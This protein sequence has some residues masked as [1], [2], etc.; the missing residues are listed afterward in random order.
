MKKTTASKIKKHY[1]V[2]TMGCQM[3]EYD[4]DHLS[5]QLISNGYCGADSPDKADIIF[6]NT[7]S[8]REKA[9]QKAFSMLGRMIK[10]KKKYP[11]ILLG[12]TGCIAQQEGS[13]LLKKYPELDIV[14]GT[15]GTSD[16]GKILNRV[17]N[18]N[19]RVCETDLEIAPVYL[20]DKTG[21]KTDFFSGRIKNHL[22][23]ME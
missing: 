16:L 14:L 4:T 20:T 22:S 10:L 8:V 6:I 11:D 23:V 12:F 19:E 2:S 3:N 7:C 13:L 9:E 17:I 1:Y 15:R 5:R 21:N 18:Y